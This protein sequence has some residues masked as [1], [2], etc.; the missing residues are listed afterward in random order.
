[1][2]MLG[3]SLLIFSRLAQI[4][5]GGC[6]HVAMETTYRCGP[7]LLLPPPPLP[8]PPRPPRDLAVRPPDVSDG[9][10]EFPAFPILFIIISTSSV[11]LL[12]AFNICYKALSREPEGS[13]ENGLNIGGNNN[14][15]NES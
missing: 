6:P 10:I 11:I 12:M 8:P 1:M 14:N 15:N 7:F 13:R 4:S 9:G 5:W 3:V 2:L